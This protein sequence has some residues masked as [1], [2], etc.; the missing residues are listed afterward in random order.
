LRTTKDIEVEVERWLSSIEMDPNPPL[1]RGA[2]KRSVV[3]AGRKWAE[4]AIAPFR[5]VILEVTNER[6][7][8]DPQDGLA[9]AAKDWLQY[10]EVDRKR[11][12]LQ[13]AVDPDA[14]KA[15][16]AE[17]IFG[18][19]HQRVYFAILQTQQIARMVAED[20]IRGTLRHHAAKEMYTPLVA[21]FR[22]FHQIAGIE[23]VPVPEVAYRQSAFL[24]TQIDPGLQMQLVK[25]MEGP[26]AQLC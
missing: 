18:W 1:R 3:M 12:Q 13:L 9:T 26:T 5:S 15:A 16:S 10:L 6:L 19:Y 17:Q 11:T 21:T 2:T 25:A 22:Q 24:C 23:R 4:A 7:S 8:R 14:D 20:S